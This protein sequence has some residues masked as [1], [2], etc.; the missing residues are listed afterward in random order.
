MARLYHVHVLPGNL[1]GLG[2]NH[3]K[4]L[5]KQILARP[6]WIFMQD[7]CKILEIFFSGVLTDNNIQGNTLY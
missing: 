1:K 6:T 3:G 7:T 5:A 2:M 4:I